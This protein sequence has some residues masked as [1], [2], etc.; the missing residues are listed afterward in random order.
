MPRTRGVRRG[1]HHRC[2]SHAFARAGY[3]CLSFSL[4]RVLF[5]YRLFCA[6]SSFVARA[7][8]IIVSCRFALCC[9]ARASFFARW[10][11]LISYFVRRFIIFHL[12]ARR[13][14][15]IAAVVLSY[16]MIS[17]LGVEQKSNATSSRIASFVCI[18]PG[19]I[20]CSSHAAR[21]RISVIVFCARAV[22]RRV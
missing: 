9:C 12:A 16:N 8:R 6:S 14:A 7:L 2:I 13:R 11:A 15:C 10:R 17:T 5:L 18:C 21:T 20:S 1:R 3:A 19:D 22:H 4:S